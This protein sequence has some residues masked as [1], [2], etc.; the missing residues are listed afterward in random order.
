M[1]CLLTEIHL[2]AAGDLEESNQLFFYLNNQR[3]HVAKKGE[4]FPTLAIQTFKYFIFSLCFLDL[5]E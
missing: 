5:P 3:A 1:A 4:T 2:N